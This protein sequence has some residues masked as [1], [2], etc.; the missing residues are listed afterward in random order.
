MKIIMNIA[1]NMNHQKIRHSAKIQ[2]CLKLVGH[3]RVHHTARWY[4][5]CH[6]AV[7][8]D[9]GGTGATAKPAPTKQWALRRAFLAPRFVFRAPNVTSGYDVIDR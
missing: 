1:L 8:I 7:V 3:A 4:C 2:H 5:T 9:R 6:A